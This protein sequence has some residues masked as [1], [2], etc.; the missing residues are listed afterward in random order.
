M[1]VTCEAL[2]AF[3]QSID[4]SSGEVAFRAAIGRAYYG[5]YHRGLQWEKQLQMPG[6][7]AGP[8]GGIHQQLINRLTNPDA[9][10]PGSIKVKSRSLAYR[11]TQMKITRT[12][13]D[14][15][16]TA[17]FTHDE[18][19]QTVALARQLLIDYS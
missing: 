1:A 8:A 6:S 4:Q 7:N 3:G 5:A 13:A 2:V 17:S 14:Y 15:D 10:C 11:L 16:L 9:N 19:A 12:T 18:V